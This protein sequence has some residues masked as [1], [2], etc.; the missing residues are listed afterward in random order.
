MSPDS[1]IDQWVIDPELWSSFGF[2]SRL[3]IPVVCDVTIRS[4]FSL[5]SLVAASIFYPC[6]NHTHFWL[7]FYDRFFTRL[8]ISAYLLL[9]SFQPIPNLLS[10]ITHSKHIYHSSVYDLPMAPYCLWNKMANEKS[11]L[12]SIPEPMSYISTVTEMG[13][14]KGS[15]ET[16]EPTN[17]FWVS[18]ELSGS[19]C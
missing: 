6:S 4:D 9:L 5:C 13:I 11:T 1:P 7:A 12:N 19:Y 14:D 18:S 15:I 10:R 2:S 8:L 17:C 3:R 16:Y